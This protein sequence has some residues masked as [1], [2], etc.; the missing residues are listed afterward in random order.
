MSERQVH[1]V[2]DDDAVR[3]ALRVLL[4]ISGYDV[5]TYDSGVR[6]LEEFTGQE[7]GC[8]ITDV[9]MPGITG[10][11]MAARLHSLG[12]KLPIIVITGQAD[13]PMAVEAMKAGVRD[14]I[15]KPFD[16]VAILNAVEAA[17][18]GEGRTDGGDNGERAELRGRIDALTPRERQVLTALVAGKANKVTAR[19]LGIS[20]RT[21][22]IYRA[23][24]MSKMR[25]GSL[26]EL[27]RMAISAGETA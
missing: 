11:A 17:L 5:K 19:D 15:E 18:A 2:D 24:V 1:V 13:V 8:V 9:R 10:L 27:V 16:D 6:F 21:V 22:A 7:R 26:S 25:A 23:N 4:Q 12:S 20:P 3:D 14:F